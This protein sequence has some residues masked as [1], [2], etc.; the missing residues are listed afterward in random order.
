MQVVYLLNLFL[1]LMLMSLF[2][3]RYTFFFSERLPDVPIKVEYPREAKEGLWAGE[4]IVKGFMHP[5]RT[6]LIPFGHR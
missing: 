2:D 3:L 4:G 5:R 1:N 6:M